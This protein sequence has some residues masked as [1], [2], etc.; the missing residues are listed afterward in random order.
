MSKIL[1]CELGSFNVEYKDEDGD[2]ILMACD[3]NVREYLQL[4]TS[5]GNKVTKLKIRDKVRNTT[6]LCETCESLMRKRARHLQI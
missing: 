6:N 5:L 4:L 2:W 1:E 3:E